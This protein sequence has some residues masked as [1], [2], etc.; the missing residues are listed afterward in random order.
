MTAHGAHDTD[1]HPGFA[2]LTIG[3]ASA[4]G[5]GWT[6]HHRSRVPRHTVLEGSG[7]QCLHLTH[8][9]DSHRST[10]HGRIRI[11]TSYGALARHLGTGEGRLSITVAATRTA[12]AIAAEITRRLL[13]EHL[14]LPAATISRAPAAHR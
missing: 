3:V 7:Q 10:D 9:D 13:P 1:P 12:E 4:L 6:V 14:A 8:G 5:P 11:T 2:D